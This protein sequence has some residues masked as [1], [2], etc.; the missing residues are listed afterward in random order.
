MEIQAVIFD[1]DHTLLY[2][3]SAQLARI[4][5]HMTVLAPM[6]PQNVVARAWSSWP[7]PWPHSA[8]EE[9][10]FWNEFWQ[11]VGHTYDLTPGQVRKL[12]SQ[13]GGVYHTVFAA[14]PDSDA[15]LRR[16]HGAGLRLA[17]LTN[18]E[19]PSVDRTLA[20]AGLDPTL[21]EVLATSAAL[22]I[23]KP[24]L[25]AFQAV[26]DALALPPAA[27][28][29]IDDLAENVAAA[30]SIGMRA[31]QID[32]SLAADDLATARISSLASLAGLLLPP[33]VRA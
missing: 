11:T 19:L 20:H 4:E 23:Y 17:V 26:T 28:L 13:I 5:A 7:G 3:D 30:R 12:S 9:P 22:G 25:G 1:R 31:Y 18:F 10:A 15:C 2:F 14:Y 16:L 6:L 8:D 21:F 32:R 24:D 29:F 27:C 33:S